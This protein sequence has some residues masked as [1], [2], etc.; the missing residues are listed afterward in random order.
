MMLFCSLF[1]VYCH[2][3]ATGTNV[4]I[5][6]V[7]VIG[8][9]AAATRFEQADSKLVWAGAWTSSPTTSASGSSFK[10]ADTS[11]A[12]VTVKF[13]GIS[14]NLIAKKSPLYGIAEIKLDDQPAV[15]VDFYNS[16]ALFKQTVWKSGFLAPGDHTVTIKWTGTKRTAATDYNIDLDAVDVIGTL[17]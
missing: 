5:D 1:S 7:D 17:R 9:L 13:T 16:T 6:A 2:T 8:N 14:C 10:F 15:L 12:S 3:A 11:G 4:G